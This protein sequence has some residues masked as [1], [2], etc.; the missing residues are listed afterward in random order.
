MVT[1][2]CPF[3]GGRCGGALFGSEAYVGG[4]REGVV[5][6]DVVDNVFFLLVFIYIEVV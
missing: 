5:A 6:E 2:L 3:S 4:D 1:H